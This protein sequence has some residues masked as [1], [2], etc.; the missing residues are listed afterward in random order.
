MQ[1]FEAINEIIASHGFNKYLEIG[2][3]DPTDCFDLVRCNTKHSVD[4][5][6]EVPLGHNHATYK[7]ESDQFFKL[8]KN[9]SLDL[10]KDYKWDV[11]FI[12]AL[13]IASQVFQDFLNSKKHISENGFIVFH[14]CNPPSI[15]LA[16]ED[17][18]IN[19][20]RSQ[21]NG[22]VWKAI[23][24]IRTEFDVDFIT[25]DDDWGIGVCRFNKSASSRLSPNVNPFY[26][27]NKFS[28]N[29]NLI[30]N[31][32]PAEEFLSWLNGYEK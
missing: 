27:Y 16:R 23:Q 20:V 24:R 22:T 32:K 5:G 28:Q 4:P 9:G 25:I 30:L 1:R 10:E 29:R 18:I 15:N 21:W 8:L 11:I 13:H 7:L 17:Y 6:Y 14:D 26:E 12:D 2:V 3:C 19:G 31:L